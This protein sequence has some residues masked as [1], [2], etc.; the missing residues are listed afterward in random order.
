M[1]LLLEDT[2]LE[3]SE[4]VANASMNRQRNLNGGNSYECELGLDLFELLQKHLAAHPY[5]AWLDLCCGGGRALIQAAGMCVARGLGQRV[6]FFGVDLVP[7]FDSI[8]PGIDFLE[9][10]AGSVMHWRP[11]IRFDLITCV[12]GL[13]YIGDK[14]SFMTTAAGWLTTGG[15]FLAHLDYRNL[16]L[17]GKKHAGAIIGRDLRRAGFRY[18]ARRHLVISRGLTG[19]LVGYR[20]LGADDRAG[21]NYTGQA[22][23]DSH[24]ER[25]TD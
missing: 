19:T 6:R 15:L 21:S 14:L 24:Y 9:L 25:V 13:H 1:D 22:A 11:G 4:V 20:Y 2:A 12:H 8:P 5:F 7:M 3:S 18:Q 17:R 10:R 23:V 16:K